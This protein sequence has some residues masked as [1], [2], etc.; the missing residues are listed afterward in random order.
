ME[1]K[2]ISSQFNI[3]VDNNTVYIIRTIFDVLSN[4]SNDAEKVAKMENILIMS[5]NWLGEHYEKQIEKLI[6][7]VK[8]RK[9]LK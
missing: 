4:G 6:E 1:Q 9:T 2:L 8:E 3:P 5:S 7:Y